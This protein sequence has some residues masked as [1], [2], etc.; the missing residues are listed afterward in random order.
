MPFPQCSEV[1]V[2]CGEGE[3]DVVERNADVSV[4]ASPDVFAGVVLHVAEQRLDGL[5]K[6]VANICSLNGPV[7]S[8]NSW[9]FFF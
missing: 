5:R 4:H 7:F 3:V 2:G 1:E 8:S 9:V 6:A